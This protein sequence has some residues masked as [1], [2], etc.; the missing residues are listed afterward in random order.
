[1]LNITNEDN[2]QLMA[3]YPDNYFDLA[4]VDPP[5]Q[6]ERFS[7]NM[8]SQGTLGKS[9]FLGKNKISKEWDSSTHKRIL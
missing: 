4:I 6:I 2:M 3:R 8:D 1:M 9:I 5:Y 7:K